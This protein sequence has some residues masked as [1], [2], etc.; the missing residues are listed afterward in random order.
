MGKGFLRLI[1]FI[2]FTASWYVNAN[3]TFKG[4]LQLHVE[5]GIMN[6]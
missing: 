2:E 4:Y 1:N 3:H 6:A 5:I